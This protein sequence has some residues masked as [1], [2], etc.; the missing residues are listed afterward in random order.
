MRRLPAATDGP[1]DQLAQP[2][3]GYA[4]FQSL[5]MGRL[6]HRLRKKL[7]SKAARAYTFGVSALLLAAL[8]LTKRWVGYGTSASDGMAEVWRLLIP[9]AGVFLAEQS[10]SGRF[11]LPHRVESG[12]S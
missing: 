3:F 4:F 5:V 7:F 10:A 8:R 2:L 6:V 1:P 11:D 9:T 12:S